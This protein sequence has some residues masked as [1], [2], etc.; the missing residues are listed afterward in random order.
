METS[1]REVY[2]AVARAFDAGELVCSPI[3]QGSSLLGD[4][5]SRCA[6]VPIANAIFGICHT[7]EQEIMVCRALTLM[8]GRVCG[9]DHAW[10]IV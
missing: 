8:R 7:E 10:K 1:F 2:E 6:V 4:N 5:C 3:V 9:R